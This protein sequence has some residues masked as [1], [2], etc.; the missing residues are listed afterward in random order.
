MF[1]LPA[2][3]DGQ[4]AAARRVQTNH[5]RGLTGRTGSA[6]RE[7]GFIRG[8]IDLLRS[9]GDVPHHSSAEVPGASQRTRPL[10]YRGIGRCGPGIRFARRKGGSRRL[11]GAASRF[12]G[13]EVRLVSPAEQMP[14]C[15][16]EA[17]VSLAPASLGAFAGSD[18]GGPHQGV[19]H[20]GTVESCRRVAIL[21]SLQLA[22]PATSRRIPW[23]PL[24]QTPRM[25]PRWARIRRMN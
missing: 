11:T 12:P 23:P 21:S 13:L 18:R 20:T 10:R 14:R 2:G 4:K 1:G 3:F 16:F 24:L 17:L 22:P 19:S 6:D 15:G 7:T 9:V 25:I 8:V 5:P